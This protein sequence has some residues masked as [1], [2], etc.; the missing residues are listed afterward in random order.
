MRRSGPDRASGWGTAVALLAWGVAVLAFSAGGL[1]D[2]TR[3][4]WLVLLFGLAAPVALLAVRHR[5][6]GGGA[7]RGPRGAE[8][9]LL[10]ALRDYGELTPTAA[11]VLTP[12]TAAEAAR[13]LEKLADAGHLEARV[14]GGAIH[15]ALREGDRR[16]ITRARSATPAGSAGGDVPGKESANAASLSASA[17]PPAESLTERELAVL[18]LV[19]KGRTNRGIA[20]ELFIAEGTVK[21]HVASV[22]R[23]LGVRSR[24]EAVAR[25][26]GLGLI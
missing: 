6:L 16:A 1:A 17:L 24:A 15:Y 2:V 25:A 3:L 19:A 20:K 7:I 4:W 26:A 5:I 9:E 18:G 23:K 12:L 22:H 10:G 14:E 11:A 8:Q 13:A 21:A